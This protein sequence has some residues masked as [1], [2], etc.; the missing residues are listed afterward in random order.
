[1]PLTQLHARYEALECAVWDLAEHE[2]ISRKQ[3]A[4]NMQRQISFFETQHL[5]DVESLSPEVAIQLE[6]QLGEIS[7]DSAPPSLF[8]P[9]EE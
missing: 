2:G 8:D 9:L 4:A 5:L 3:Y 7:P 6:K 1:M